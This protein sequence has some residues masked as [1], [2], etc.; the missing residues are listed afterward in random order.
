M[1]FS[2]AIVSPIQETCS[3][4]FSASSPGQKFRCIELGENPVF[5]ETPSQTV[6][7]LSSHPS[8]WDA[9]LS[10]IQCRSLDPKHRG[11]PQ[12]YISGCDCDVP[13]LVELAS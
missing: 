4:H 2:W 8:A 13:S 9:P 5:S 11:G 3:S 1:A 7:L 6:T 12:G 10:R